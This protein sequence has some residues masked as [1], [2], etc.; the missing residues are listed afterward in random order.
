VEDVW[1]Y[2]KWFEPIDGVWAHG[3]RRLYTDDPVGTNVEFISNETDTDYTE[4]ARV[5]T[6]YMRGPGAPRLSG[7]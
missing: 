1:R 2:G 3:R 4:F 6:M 7:L 5:S